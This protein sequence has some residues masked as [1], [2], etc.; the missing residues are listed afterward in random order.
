MKPIVG[1]LSDDERRLL[2]E[3]RINRAQEA[4]EDARV[5]FQSNR[6]VN[7]VNRC[8]YAMFYM[9]SALALLDGFT[10]SKHKQMLGWFNRTYIASRVLDVRLKNILV[11]AFD[12]RDDGDYQDWKTFTQEEIEQL[13][14]DT[15]FFLAELDEFIKTRLR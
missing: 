10:S 2:V 5:A 13:C 15:D 7:T 8:Y 12:S 11:Y 1:T 6:F 9:V 4:R 14:T 3:H